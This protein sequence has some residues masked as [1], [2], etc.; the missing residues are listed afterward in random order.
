MLLDPNLN[1]SVAGI[2]LNVHSFP[3]T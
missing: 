3:S 2:L 1:K